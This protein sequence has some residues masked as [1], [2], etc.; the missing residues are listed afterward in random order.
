MNVASEGR[1]LAQ[2]RLSGGEH[3][4]AALAKCMASMWSAAKVA[5]RRSVRTAR[6]SSSRSRS[7][8]ASGAET[9]I[10]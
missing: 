8:K 6:R 10:E 3:R 7:L 4:M 2:L 1:S 9:K 5:P